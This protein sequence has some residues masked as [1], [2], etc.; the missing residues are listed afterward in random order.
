MKQRD[1][2]RDRGDDNLVKQIEAQGA[3][4]QLLRHLQG[5]SNA[6][7][8]DILAEVHQELPAIAAKAGVALIVSRADYLS[9]GVDTVDVTDALVELFKPD[10]KT[11]Q[12]IA[13]LRQ[14]EPVAML[15]II[16]KK[17]H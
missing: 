7:V 17:E 1:D 13:E 6:P 16:G 15:Q 11:T 10:E 3:A 4:R 8:D 5:F 2:A 14:R 12:T 9:A